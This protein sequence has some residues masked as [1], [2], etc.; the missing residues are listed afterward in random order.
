MLKYISTLPQKWGKT[1]KAL[2][3][4]CEKY[5][6]K[7]KPAQPITIVTSNWLMLEAIL[8]DMALIR[9]CSFKNKI[10]PPYSPIR[11]GVSMVILQPASTDLNALRKENCC[12]CN[13]SSCHFFASIPQLTSIKIITVKNFQ[14]FQLCFTCCQRCSKSGCCINCLYKM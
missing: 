13:T 4:L 1:F 9:F 7:I 10:L 14:L 3:M 8:S 6:K 11:L 5:L 2:L 12:I